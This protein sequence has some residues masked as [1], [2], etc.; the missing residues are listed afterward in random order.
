MEVQIP[1][2][3]GP[4]CLKLRNAGTEADTIQQGKKKVKAVSRALKSAQKS[5]R[6][7]RPRKSPS[8]PGQAILKHVAKSDDDDPPEQD[9]GSTAWREA[10][11]PAEY[12]PG[13]SEPI[14]IPIPSHQRPS[15][16][17]T[18][19]NDT[20]F[21]E[22]GRRFQRYG[23]I[24]GSPQTTDLSRPVSLS[25]GEPAL[26]TNSDD[27][28]LRYS[29]KL[30]TPRR[31]SYSAG[32][33]M[34][35]APKRRQSGPTKSTSAFEVGRTRSPARK[36]QSLGSRIV[37]DPGRHGLDGI[38]DHRGDVPYKERVSPR[39]RHMRYLNMND[40]P[41]F[42]PNREQPLFQRLLSRH[43]TKPLLPADV[44]MEA[45]V[46]IDSKQNDFWDFLDHELE[47]IETFYKSKEEQATLRLNT[48]KRQLHQLRDHRMR[49]VEEKRAEAKERKRKREE[50]GRPEESSTGSAS[51]KGHHHYG[52][53]HNIPDAKEA[54]FHP[55]KAAKQVQFRG[56]PKLLG[57]ATPP[58]RT[59][60]Q[61]RDYIRKPTHTDTS[62]T[63]AKRKLKLAMQEF[64][65]GL[66]LLKSYAL[67]NRTAFRKINKKFD[68]AV[69]P[70]KTLAYLPKVEEAWFVKSSMVDDYIATVE[71]LYA[72]YFY[73]ANRK[74]AASKL[75]R[76]N[77]L[78]NDYTPSVFRNGLALGLG[79]V[80]AVEACVQAGY[81]YYPSNVNHG[82]LWQ[83]GEHAQTVSYLMQIYAGYF[84]LLFLT[85]LFCFACRVF[86]RAKVNYVFIFEFDIRHNLDWRQLSEVSCAIL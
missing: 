39:Y 64:Y 69:K 9:Q 59:L 78:P 26:D 84:L 15:S 5:P 34:K 86:H 56:T 30:N 38:Q 16:Q 72:R 42:N 27:E 43:G 10:A 77:R 58:T 65:R 51:L 52:T 71:D 21:S 55:I 29:R 6:T 32:G 80:F 24:V 81:E 40:T 62:Y 45:Y 41:E 36:R 33:V 63:G 74:V 82:D 17:D 53:V 61:S 48:L 35:E 13:A 66:E 1:G 85:L 25:I 8:T 20:T 50:N 73:A 75:R 3:Q 44:P 54:V 31:K 83:G 79:A 28:L 70:N 68:K 18:T 7:P 49:D 60:E 47:K 57:E 76:K 23:S 19:S 67:L 46:E 14:Q 11:E 37:S 4:L 2:L 12:Q 22:G